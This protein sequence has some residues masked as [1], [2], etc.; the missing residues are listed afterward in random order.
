MLETCNQ[1]T[2]R[3]HRTTQHFAVC[4]SA[5]TSC[6]SQQSP[7][8]KEDGIFGKI[9]KQIL[10]IKQIQAETWRERLADVGHGFWW[11]PPSPAENLRF[12]RLMITHV[13]EL[14]EKHTEKNLSFYLT[15][16]KVL[17]DT[18]L[19]WK[20]FMPHQRIFLMVFEQKSHGH[21]SLIR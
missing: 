2:P 10:R 3:P 11:S 14:C 18:G 12:R 7:G 9:Q 4:L 19:C 15:P 8:K 16:Q 17:A 20:V 6:W 21:V 13:V 1:T 5:G